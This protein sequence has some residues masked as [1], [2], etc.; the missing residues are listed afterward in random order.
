[1]R[2]Q[3]LITSLEVAGYGSLSWYANLLSYSQNKSL[4]LV[5]YLKLLQRCHFCWG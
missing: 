2:Y 1:M 4:R 5:Y 3:L